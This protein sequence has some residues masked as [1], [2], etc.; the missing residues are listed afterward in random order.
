MQD[1]GDNFS[2]MRVGEVEVISVDFSTAQCL[3]TGETIT[4]ASW[5]I[6]GDTTPSMLVTP[7]SIVGTVCSIYIKGVT[8]GTFAPLCTVTT[9][10]GQ[11][12][13]LPDPGAGLLS[14]V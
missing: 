3:A 11:T 13:T 5:A 12:L 10:R 14:I 1:I 9:S 8:K 7:Q 4:G 2:P 6:A